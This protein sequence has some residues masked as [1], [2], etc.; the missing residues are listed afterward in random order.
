MQ[1]EEY[2]P[3]PPEAWKG[4]FNKPGMVRSEVSRE[5]EEDKSKWI[6]AYAELHVCTDIPMAS[7][8]ETILDYAIYPQIFKRNKGMDVV[9]EDGKVYHDMVAG[10]EV[11]GVAYTMWFRQQVTVVIDEPDRLLLD[12]SHVADDGRVKDVRG[13]WY[14]ES[15]PGTDWTYVRYYGASRVVQRFPLQRFIMSILIDGETK[16]ALVQFLAAARKRNS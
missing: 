11:F 13:A 9:Y 7:L 4:L 5:I 8:R 2:E 12:F 15:L 14:F 16:D 10:I 6:D 1:G 3:P